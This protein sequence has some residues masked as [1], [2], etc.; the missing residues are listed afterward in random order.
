M[1]T[2]SISVTF[3]MEVLIKSFSRRTYQWRLM[4]YDD[5]KPYIE[6]VS[7]GEPSNVI[8]GDTVASFISSSGTFRYFQ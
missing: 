1:Q 4:S 5:V 3:S 2:P 8:A 7:K 6:R